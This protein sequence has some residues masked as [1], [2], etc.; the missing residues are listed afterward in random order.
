V[1][2]NQFVSG[3]L[4]LASVGAVGLVFSSLLS[5]TAALVIY[6]VLVLGCAALWSKA[7]RG[8]RKGLATT[9]LF[10]LLFFPYFGLPASAFLLFW[11]FC[12]PPPEDGRTELGEDDKRIFDI[13]DRL[14]KPPT[15]IVS[16]ESFLPAITML[17]SPNLEDRR[18]AIEVLARIGGAEQIYHLQKCLDDPEREVHQLAHA[19]LTALHEQHTDAINQAQQ[20]SKEE[21]L[22]SVVLYLRSGLLGEATKLFYRQKA[23]TIGG[24]LLL[25]RPHDPQLLSLLGEL[26]LEDRKYQEAALAFE[27]SLRLEDSI[28]AR[29]G[30]VRLCYQ[31]RNYDGFLAH[32]TELRGLASATVPGTREI[33]EVVTWWFG[34][35]QS[36]RKT[37]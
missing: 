17:Q 7:G 23:I 12:Y 6:L 14:M 8:R 2:L 15:Q 26:Y 9:G 13:R 21:E 22:D 19:K 11:T 4:W 10:F 27:T 36:R 16:E 37:S 33:T 25:E 28:E 3:A 5:P 1:T 34:E 32:L 24:K 35:P 20:S 29:W 30:L 18:S 31:Q